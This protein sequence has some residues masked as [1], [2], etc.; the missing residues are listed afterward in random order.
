VSC[1]NSGRNATFWLSG[2]RA[3]LHPYRERWRWSYDSCR[4]PLV[5]ALSA[6][7][8]RD[9]NRGFGHGGDHHRAPRRSAIGCYRDCIA[10]HHENPAEGLVDLRQ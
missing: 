4:P 6:S 8:R 3:Q 2:I 7:T 5:E 9:R 10:H 1:L